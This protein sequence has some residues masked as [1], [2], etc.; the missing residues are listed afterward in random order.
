MSHIVLSILS[1][2]LLLPVSSP[3]APAITCHCFTDRSYDPARPSLAD[4]YFLATTQ[5]S[6]FAVVFNVDRNMIV[7]KK[8]AGSSADDLWIAY[9]IA[10]RSGTTGEA[11][12]AARGKNKSWKE[13][14]EALKLSK[15]S[16]GEKLLTDLASGRPTIS[17]AQEVVDG[18]LV[19]RRL[20]KGQD[21]ATLRNEWAS[22][23]EIIMTALIAAKS[24]RP[25]L[26]VYR[27][28]KNRAT[29]WGALLNEAKIQ[30]PGIQTEFTQLMKSAPR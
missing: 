13:V 3:A 19:G 24:K 28:V 26:Q 10:S 21:V 12:L 22:N 23:Q 25:P 4:P 1:I 20:L 11:L 18:I 6:F 9:W 27:G 15:K 14:V 5:N 30:P 8:Q 7:M 29:S 2:L 17:L 16:L